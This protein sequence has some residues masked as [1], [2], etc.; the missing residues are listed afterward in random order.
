MTKTRNK[1]TH[2]ASDAPSWFIRSVYLLPTH[3]M[4]WWLGWFEFSI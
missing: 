4:V 1:S 3:G 2:L